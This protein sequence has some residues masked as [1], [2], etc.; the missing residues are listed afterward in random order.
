MPEY[1]LILSADMY[2]RF[3]H[4]NYNYVILENRSKF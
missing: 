1:L 4:E 3:I 2:I